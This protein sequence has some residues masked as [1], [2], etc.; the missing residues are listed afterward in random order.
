MRQVVN[1][2]RKW[3]FTKRFDAIPSDVPCDWD[4]VSLPHSWN[5]RTIMRK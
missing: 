2:N 1:I 4:F 5:A 3:A